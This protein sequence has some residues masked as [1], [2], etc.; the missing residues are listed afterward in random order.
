MVKVLPE[1]N[2]P[3]G[4][5][6][7]PMARKLFIIWVLTLFAVK[8]SRSQQFTLAI[9]Q[10]MQI[11]WV[12]IDNQ[13]SCTVENR[14]QRS[15]FLRTDSTVLK[16]EKN[17]L[18]VF[19]PGAAGSVTIEVMEKRRGGSL[20]KIGETRVLVFRI[21]SAVA[22]IGGLFGGVISK[23]SLKAQMG[24][25]AHIQFLNIDIRCTVREF[26]VSIIR[27]GQSVFTEINQG[28]TFNENTK[29]YFR[30]LQKDD[31]V[32]VSSIKV[33]RPDGEVETVKPVELTIA[34]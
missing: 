10:P 31:V 2:D 8:Q 33:L 23:S 28:N 18:F 29:E 30:L 26:T 11:A 19:R 27:N 17:G 22:S 32:L 16:R 24:V 6:E 1:G 14:P 9:E 7:L 21:P 13:L 20:K 3:A 4:V 5:N 15:I 25:S 34:D 12:G